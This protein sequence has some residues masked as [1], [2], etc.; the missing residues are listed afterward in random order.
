M[1]AQKGEAEGEARQPRPHCLFRTKATGDWQRLATTTTM[2]AA[3]ATATN[4]QGRLWR[5]ARRLAATLFTEEDDE[6]READDA[7]EERA[8]LLVAVEVDGRVPV[9][10]TRDVRTERARKQP[11]H[12]SRRLSRAPDPLTPPACPSTLQTGAARSAMAT[13]GLR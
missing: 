11:P 1:H 7:G 12:R 3:R 10:A 5:V 9:S 4:E 2:P 8:G 6:E 13:A